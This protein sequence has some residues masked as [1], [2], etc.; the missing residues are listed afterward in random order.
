MAELGVIALHSAMHAPA[1]WEYE[2]RSCSFSVVRPAIPVNCNAAP[3]SLHCLVRK[4][5]W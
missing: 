1:T 4:P 3:R 2:M 5:H